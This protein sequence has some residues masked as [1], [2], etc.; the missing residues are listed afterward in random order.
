MNSHTSPCD[1]MI[2]V[3]KSSPERT[4]VPRCVTARLTVRCLVNINSGRPRTSSTAALRKPQHHRLRSPRSESKG[5]FFLK[6][7]HGIKRAIKEAGRE[8]VSPPLPEEVP[9]PPP[10]E[11]KPPPPEEVKRLKPPRSK[12]EWQP[13]VPLCAPKVN[14]EDAYF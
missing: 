1:H 4:R 5:F 8:E 2:F 12:V 13:V 7:A 6:Q 3:A 10:A 14:V 9:P 11:V